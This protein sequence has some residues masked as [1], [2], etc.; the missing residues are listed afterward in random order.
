MEFRILGPLEVTDGEQAVTVAG[1]KPRAL[2][3]ALLIRSGQTVST[4]RLI[5]ELWGDDPP[6][7]AQNTLQVYVSQLRRALGAETIVRRSSGY[8]LAASREQIDLARFEDL[9][10]SARAV[11]PHVAADR[12]RD[13]LALWR[14]EPEVDAARLE[15]L[16]LA[17]LESRI[18][19]DLA[20]GRHAELV[21]ELQALVADE[22]L[23]ERLRAQLLLA[24]YRDGR[25]ADALAEYA[26]ARKTLVDELGVEPGPELQRAHRA[27]LAHDDEAPSHPSPPVSL[28]T[29]ATPLV[30]REVELGAIAALFAD[31]A[32]LVTLTGPGGIG[33]TRLALDAARVLDEHATFVPLASVTDD[34]LVE[35]AIQRALR[36]DDDVIDHLRLRSTLLLLDNFEQ[37]LDAAQLVSSLLQAAPGVRLLV[38]SRSVLRIAGER[39]YEVPPL[40]AGVELFLARAAG[41]VDDLDAVRAICERL[42]GLPLAIELAAARTKLLP[43]GKL[44]ERL[45][46]RLE[47]LT[48]GSRDAPE[49]HRT[50]RA[51]VDWSYRLLEPEEQVL[52]ARLAVFSGGATIEQIE[53]ICGGELDLLASLAEKSLVRRRGERVVMLETLR[54]YASEQLRAL[55]EEDVLRDRHLASFVRLAAEAEPELDTA[56]QEVWYERLEAE[57]PNIRSALAHAIAKGDAAT[58]VELAGR[59]QRLWQVHG[60][61]GEGE[62]WLEASLALGEDP[63]QLAA[64]AWNGLGIVR[65]DRGDYAGAEQAFQRALELRR[66]AG[67]EPGVASSFTNL[68]A[69][70]AFGHD[71]DT[72]QRL[73]EQALAI[74]RDTSYSPNLLA[75]L[76]NI[77]GVALVRGD[78]AASIEALEEARA[79]AVEHGELRAT[80]STARWL[81]RALVEQGELERSGALLEESLALA[82]QIG[83]RQGVACALDFQAARALAAGDEPEAERLQ[84]EGAAAWASV[85]AVRPADVALLTPAFPTGPVKKE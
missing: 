67:D 6:E 37:V 69:L 27:V 64:K 41:D 24:L 43:P 20:L 4:E 47:V 28:P 18:D 29:P 57:L 48:S 25:Q 61:L 65:A 22:P 12:L 26:R 63:V 40:A 75:L 39:E 7:T 3:A 83:H 1:A 50:M 62:R 54:E 23:R 34:T 52:F 17:A 46:S 73:Y 56:Q 32:R 31:G 13:A 15:E 72:A 9:V 82:E 21:P 84:A 45:G 38:T 2:L 55:G 74:Y 51:T 53:E 19:A 42:D 71:Y 36:T 58:A 14:G 85:G 10:E 5:D 44:L 8:A 81:A 35:G 76:E 68:G 60:H 78:V 33:K 11:E 30:G 79:L 66:E 49:R 80:S 59:L 70:A 77:G 16:R